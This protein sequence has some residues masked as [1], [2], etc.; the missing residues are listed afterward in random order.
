MFW[1]SVK[2][3][4]IDYNYLPFAQ[5]ARVERENEKGSAEA[6]DDRIWKLG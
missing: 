3:S 4:N 5:E 2:V 6:E 1:G